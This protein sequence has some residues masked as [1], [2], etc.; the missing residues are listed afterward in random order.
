VPQFEVEGLDL[1]FNPNKTEK[2]KS[3]REQ[4]KK[5]GGRDVL[6]RFTNGRNGFNFF[7]GLSGVTKKP[8]LSLSKSL[9]SREEILSTP[10]LKKILEV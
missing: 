8:I 5:Q 2:H 4:A 1:V 3:D 9:C 10:G 6:M 7:N